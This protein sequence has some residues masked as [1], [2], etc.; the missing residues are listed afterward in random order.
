MTSWE[1]YIANEDAEMWGACRD[2]L[3]SKGLL[4]EEATLGDAED[5]SV[6]HCPDECDTGCP[7]HADC[8]LR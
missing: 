2:H 5:W 4:P 6:E 7:S 8:P 3:I 1:Q